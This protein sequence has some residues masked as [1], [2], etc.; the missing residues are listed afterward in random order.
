MTWRGNVN[1][2]IK[3]CWMM[4]L[5]LG[6]LLSQ[7]ISV[8]ASTEEL[9]SG[10]RYEEL[11]RKIEEYVQEHEDTTAGMTVSVFRQEES[12]Y[13]NFFGYADKEAEIVVDEDTVIE[14]GSATKL[15]VWVSVMQ[16]WEYLSNIE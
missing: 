16:L 8:Y 15:L 13:T 9:P 7:G 3:R 4:I 1:E 6:M 2:K 5:L 10:I 11:G 14:W 12:I